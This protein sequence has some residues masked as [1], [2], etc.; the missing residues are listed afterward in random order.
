MLRRAVTSDEVDGC[1]KLKINRRNNVC[2]GFDSVS[3]AWF[4]RAVVIRSI[5]YNIVKFEPN[6]LI[7]VRFSF[8]PS[9]YIVLMD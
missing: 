5:K 1:K 8:S 6:S 7:Q 4:S 2:D 3:G 9:T